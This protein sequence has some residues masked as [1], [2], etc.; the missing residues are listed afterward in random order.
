MLLC[1]LLSVS[2]SQDL[3]FKGPRIYKEQQKNKLGKAG[4]FPIAVSLFPLTVC[5]LKE[6]SRGL[7]N[8]FKVSLKVF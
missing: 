1:A 8:M 4:K 2:D 3:A 5:C 6:K 7:Q